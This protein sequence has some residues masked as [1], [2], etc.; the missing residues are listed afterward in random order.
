MLIW[1]IVTTAS[2]VVAVYIIDFNK[3]F[4]VKPVT[5]IVKDLKDFKVRTSSIAHSPACEN[6][7]ASWIC[8]M[9]VQI[10]SDDGS[11]DAN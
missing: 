10:K 2:A 3:Y 6:P 8:P 1:K 7:I 11:L 4:H 5:F 9:G